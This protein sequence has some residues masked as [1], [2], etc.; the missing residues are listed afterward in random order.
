MLRYRQGKVYVRSTQ[1]EIHFV[2]PL[3]W[4]G[5]GQHKLRCIL[6]SR[7]LVT[8]LV[9]TTEIYFLCSHEWEWLGQKGLSCILDPRWHG[10]GLVNRS[11]YILCP[12]WNRSG[13]VIT[14]SDTFCVFA[15][16]GS[17]WSTQVELHFCVLLVMGRVCSTQFEIHF[18]LCWHGYGLVDMCWD[19]FCFLAGKLRCIL[20]S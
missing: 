13:L 6:C 4:D 18:C 14:N 19:K 5:F 2:S 8:D 20:C 3:A 7:W 10:K 9:N 1:V 16:M 17:V 11:C 15:G 12:V